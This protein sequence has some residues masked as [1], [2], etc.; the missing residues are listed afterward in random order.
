MN[1]LSLGMKRTWARTINAQNPA[2]ALCP[3]CNWLRTMSADKC[4]EWPPKIGL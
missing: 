3:V 2:Q 1:A 4:A